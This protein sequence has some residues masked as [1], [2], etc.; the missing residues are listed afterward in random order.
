MPIS[1]PLLLLQSLLF[2]VEGNISPWWCIM[3]PGGMMIVESM[4]RLELCSVLSDLY[5]AREAQLKSD[6]KKMSLILW[7]IRI[8][9]LDYLFYIRRCTFIKYIV[10]R[11]LFDFGEGVSDTPLRWFWGQKIRFINI[12][13]KASIGTFFF[14]SRHAKASVRELSPQFKA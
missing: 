13:Y 3:R 5:H 12:T 8:S 6:F 1:L 9:P 2:R 4:I 7:K 14:R 11:Y 10:H